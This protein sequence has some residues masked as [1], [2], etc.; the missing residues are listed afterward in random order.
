MHTSHMLD[1]M[2]SSTCYDLSDLRAEL[3]CFL[4][5]YG[6]SVRL[7]EDFD[8][9]FEV[10]FDRD[11]IETC[12]ANVA[13][14]DAVVLV[15]DRRYGPK[16]PD[17]S[18]YPGVSAT[19][20]EILHADS[21]RKP[22]ISF[23][24]KVALDDYNTYRGRLKDGA[25]IADALKNLPHIQ[26]EKDDRREA[27]MK[28]IETRKALSDQQ[29]NNWIDTFENS[30]DLRR[31]VLRRLEQA[32]PDKA[33]LA[34]LRRLSVPRLVIENL[35]NTSG[36]NIGL[37]VLNI[38]PGPAKSI[39]L[40]ITSI[41]AE[42]EKVFGFYASAGGMLEGGRLL[43]APYFKSAPQPLQNT[44]APVTV[45]CR[46]QN[47]AGLTCSL[48]AEFRRVDYNYRLVSETLKVNLDATGKAP[49]WYTLD[50]FNHTPRV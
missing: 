5:E 41:H 39:T 50:E 47:P 29:K 7:S 31:R 15:V 30:V 20:A 42:T 35:P 38:G 36:G 22:V 21:Q 18:R 10:K 34:L 16:L 43:P 27:L 37:N 25:S 26:G 6:M 13:A 2:I 23:I 12:L 49:D 40:R 44:L 46:Y 17:N 11:S 4:A 1:V 9:G 32:L 28:L 19:E 8:S 3:K 48:D 14:T 45:H 24:R 33:K